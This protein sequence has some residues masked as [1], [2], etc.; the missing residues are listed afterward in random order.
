MRASAALLLLLG[1][2]MP[3]QPD[4]FFESRVRPVLATKCYGCHGQEKQ[5]GNL[6]LDSRDRILRGGKSGPA[7]EPGKPRE[8]LL[9][10]AVRHEGLQMPV[11][12]KLKAEE[13][14]ALEQW[15]ATGLPWPEDKKVKLAAGDPGFYE[16]LIREHWSFQPVKKS[17]A[18]EGAATNPIDR[19]IGAKLQSSGIAMAVRAGSH[20]LARRAAYALTGLP[21]GRE[22]VT[23]FLNDR[24]PAAYERFV[25]KL[26][27]SPHFGE[28]W[29]RHWM[30]LVRYAETYGYEWNY[31]IHSAWRYRDYLIRAFNSD[32]PYD[33]FI[34]EHI[35]GDLLP[36]PRTLD[37]GRSN[38][39]VLATA[40]FRLGEMGHDNC[41]QFPEI[42]TD[43]VDNQIDTLTKAFQG[44]TVSCARCHDH[45]I[46]PIPTEDYYALYGILNSSRPVTRTL[47]L[48]GPDEATRER[49]TSLKSQIRSALASAWMHESANIGRYLAAAISWE[50]D[51]ADATRIAEGL[52]VSRIDQ[53]RTL[54]QRTNVDMADPLYPAAQWMRSSG[55]AEWRKIVDSY[56]DEALKRQRFNAEKFIVLADFRNGLPAGW[57]GDGWGYRTGRS[58]DGDFAVATEGGDALSGVFPAGLFTNLLSDRLNGVLRS[59]LLPRDKKFLTMQ[60][61]GGNLGAYRLILDHCVIGEDH[62]LLKNPNLDWV[63]TPAKTDQPLPTYLEIS[64]KRDNPR[65]PERPEK[66][67]DFSDD[68]LASPRSFWGVT[69]ILLHD[70]EVAP[71]A[72]LHHM[73]RLLAGSAPGTIQEAAARFEST[74]RDAIR[75]WSE[76]RA[77]ADGVAWIDWLLQN[78]LLSNSRNVSSELRALTGEYRKIEAEL[79]DPAIVYSMAD[80][81]PGKDYPILTGG[82]ARAPGRPAPRHFLSLMP[83]SLRKIN[84]QQSGRRELAEAIASKDNPLTARVMVNRI[85][86]HVFGRGLVATTD[87]FGRYGEPPTHPELLDHL[88]ARFVE[89]GWSIKKLMRMMVLSDTFRQSSG[90]DAKAVAAD[91]QNLLWHRYPIRRLEAEAV[92]DS[93]LAVSGALDPK[94]FGP[95]LQPRRDE[96]KPYRRLF[97]GSLDGEG[98]RSIYLKITRM[99]GPQFLEIFDFPPPMQTRGNRDVTNV[100]SQSLALLNDPFVVA[101][102]RVWAERLVSRRDDAMDGRLSFMFETALGRTASDEEL[103]RMRV[104]VESLARRHSVETAGTLSSIAVWKDVAHTFFNM[105]EFIYLR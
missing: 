91:P 14:S 80:V 51:S 49:L 41:N 55:A 31:E 72:E 64:T 83:E 77:T 70:E 40:F 47:D 98:R 4:D 1:T 85:W 78:G 42:R 63:R 39:S 30:D 16:K 25:D 69:R 44:V 9:I 58:K 17:A 45:K 15:V 26:L 7:A 103:R 84:P 22:D 88:A 53:F 43:V 81:D 12:G 89:D 48:R 74:V 13:I 71:K 35:A 92:R 46:D 32:L 3:G 96:A 66:F 20:T 19:F 102:A 93:I 62:Q 5:F 73:D 23:A 18:P 94:L 75:A 27:A 37:N 99:E 79:P 67:K 21:P 50:N 54:L 60:I 97:Q 76:N 87:D 11:G 101:Q 28:R 57:S 95:S 105:K 29:A 38:E 82:Q 2:P 104:L 33:R 6:R 56:R 24:S 10:K 68:Q 100:P 8:S 65:L 52:T 86:H 61:A 90:A 36:N 34:R 59:P